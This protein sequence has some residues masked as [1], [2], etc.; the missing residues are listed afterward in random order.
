MRFLKKYSSIIL[1]CVLI[2][3]TLVIWFL[4]SFV[5]YHG[6]YLK[7]AFLDIGQ[8]DSIYVEAPNGKQLLVD[9]GPPDGKVL[10]KLP[11][12]MPFADR[13][14]DV[15]LGTHVDS[16]HIGG[17]PLVLENYKIGRVVENGAIGTTKVYKNFETEISKN[18]IPKTIARRGMKIVLDK[19]KNIYFEIL[20]PDRD[21]SGMISNDGSIVGKLVYGKDSFMLTGDA[22]IYTENLI[23]WNE[24][25][26]TL[27]ST[28]LKLGHHGSRTSSSLM[29]LKEVNPSTAIIS[30]G[31][32]NRYGHPHKEVLGRLKQLNIPYL[33]TYKKGTIMFETDGDNLIL[34]K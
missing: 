33:A 20:F 23:S 16:D 28:V 26:N 29:W 31:L 13:S 9:A 1:V 12:V 14:I 7:V 21:I 19:E 27:H 30:A 2:L 18:K 4:P 3:A 11:E 34:V 17:F 22:T 25:E 8:G 32:N 24:D 15:V 5:N 6:K 10:Q